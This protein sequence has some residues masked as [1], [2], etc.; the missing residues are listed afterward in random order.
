MLTP[1]FKLRQDLEFLYIIIYLPYVK[2]SDCEIYIEGCE[3][4]CYV[5]P[6]LLKLNLPHELVEDGREK[7]TYNVEEGVLECR[8]PKKLQAQDFEDLELL[9]NLLN[10][11]K[12]PSAPVRPRI[13]CIGETTLEVDEEPLPEEDFRY[14]FN[15]SYVDLFTNLVE[16]LYELADVNPQIVS[17][18][19]RLAAVGPQEQADFDL[20]RYLNDMDDEELEEL[21]RQPFRELF[22]EFLP[23]ISELL[24]PMSLDAMVRL[25]NKDLL[26]N[27]N[28]V[29]VIWNQLFDLVIAFSYE[30]RTMGGD[31]TCESA[32]NINKLAVSLS[33][34]AELQEPRLVLRSFLRRVLVYGVFRECSLCNRALS[35]AQ[36]LFAEG[37]LCLVRVLLKIKSLFERSEPRYLLNRLFID[38][39]A[40]WLQKVP[41]EDFAVFQQQVQELSH[42]SV[43]ESGLDFTFEG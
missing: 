24:E 18:R 11:K 27:A 9:A 4:S 33:C 41:G 42:I 32:F 17:V 13:E 43:E 21:D 14:G 7:A 12:A 35:D 30:L 28:L 31:F 29:P 37:R 6:Y 5:K 8:V 19:D 34:L 23:S 39:I 1:R 38:D 40:I 26:V 3:F 25:G 22:A 16:E 20:D 2:V 15:R 10:P 36:Q